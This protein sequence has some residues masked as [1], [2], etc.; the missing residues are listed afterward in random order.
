M[1]AIICERYGPPEVLQ[2]KDL[3]KPV[4]AENQV[5]VKVR[6]S[7]INP[8]DRH[9]M[10]GGLAIRLVTG[11][12]APKIAGFGRDL[13]GQ[14]ESVG[15]AVTQFKPGDEVY[16][17]AM[18]AF[19]EYVC[20]AEDR[21]ALKPSNVSFEA[22]ASAPVAAL[23]ALQG[24]RD[25]GKIRSGE[26]VLVKSASGG[27]GTFAVQIARAFGA[28]VTAVCSSRHVDLARS[29]GAERVIDYSREDFTNNGQQ[30]D[31]I[32]DAMADHP[33]SDYRRALTPGGRAIMA[34]Y[35]EPLM[36]NLFRIMILGRLAARS[37]GKEVGFM[38]IARINQPDLVLLAQML[39]SGKVKPVLDKSFTL[40][41]AADAV[42]YF[43]AGHIRGK[44]II[45]VAG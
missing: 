32:F 5:L 19:A 30:Y 4:P 11:L 16:G 17:S 24:L 7:S 13:A 44:I 2:L 9:T 1:K 23:T 25:N 28:H 14:V 38:G 29:L 22:A 40:P 42:R 8:A 37:G 45:T 41:E 34:G 31:L 33:V 27:V 36:T 3:P 26:A 43:E 18:G 12:R 20:A 21:L 39:E 6:A 10:R 15:S 35:A